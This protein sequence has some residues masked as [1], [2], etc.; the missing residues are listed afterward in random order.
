M[1]NYVHGLSSGGEPHYDGITLFGPSDNVLI[2]HNTVDTPSAGGTSDVF[3][4][5]NFGPLNNIT[6]RNNLLIGAPSYAIYVGGTNILIENNYIQRGGF[7]Y[8]T[9]GGESPVIRNNILWQA[10]VDPTPY[11]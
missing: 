11:P 10:G 6:I 2:E 4:A 8:F 7:G 3:L 1:D 5:G 9:D